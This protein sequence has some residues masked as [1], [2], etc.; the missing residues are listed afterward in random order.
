M[1]S[2]IGHSSSGRSRGKTAKSAIT[3]DEVEKQVREIGNEIENKNVGDARKIRYWNERDLGGE[4]KRN[5]K[6]RTGNPGLGCV[7]RPDR[8]GERA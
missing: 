1:I 4:R 5:V 8:S 2:V 6:P 3:Q 7:Q